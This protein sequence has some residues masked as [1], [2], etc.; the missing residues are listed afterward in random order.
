MSRIKFGDEIP[1]DFQR[2]REFLQRVAPEKMT[3]AIDTIMESLSVLA[4]TP[5]VGEPHPLESAPNM[6]KLVIP[7]GKSGYIALYTFDEKADLVTI[8][9]MRHQKELDLMLASRIF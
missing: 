6:R 1:A 2:F 8:H 4:H 9:A 3:D 7:Y 5:F